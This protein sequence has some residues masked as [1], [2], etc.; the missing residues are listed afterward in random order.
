V[1]KEIYGSRC[2]NQRLHRTNMMTPNSLGNKSQFLSMISAQET[3]TKRSNWSFLNPRKMGGIRIRER[4]FSQLINW[5]IAK[6]FLSQKEAIFALRI[7]WLKNEIA[8][9]STFLVAVNLI[10]PLQLI[11]HWVMG[12]HIRRSLCMIWIWR[13]INIIKPWSQLVT[14]S[15]SMILINNSH[16]LVLVQN[17][18]LE[19]L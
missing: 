12:I 16:A 9:L 4:L 6:I 7:S 14:Y 11:L 2:I 17:F 8:S 5:K 1:A 3:L 19:Y 18:H 10:W 15:N 13:R